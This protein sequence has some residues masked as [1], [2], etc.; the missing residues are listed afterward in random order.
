MNFIEEKDEVLVAGF[1]CKGLAV[2]DIPGVQFQVVKVPV[3]LFDLI[4]RL[5]GKAKN[6]SLMVSMIVHNSKTGLICF[7]HA[8][9]LV[10]NMYIKLMEF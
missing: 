7:L 2:G 9:I 3:S 6:I 1:G 5:E 4:Q 8:I 10:S